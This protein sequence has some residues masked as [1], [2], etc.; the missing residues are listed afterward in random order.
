MSAVVVIPCYRSVLDPDEQLSIRQCLEVLGHHDLCVVAPEGLDL[1]GLL[2]DL[3]CERFPAGC[4]ADIGA[5]NRLL[6]GPEFYVRFARHEYLLIHQLDAYVFRDELD[7]WCGRGVDYVGAPWPDDEFLRKRKWR[8]AFPLHLRPPM[9]ARCIRCCDFRVGNG[10]FSLR[11]IP[12]FLAVLDRHAVAARDWPTNED[13][14]WSLAAPVYDRKFRIPPEREAMRF[15]VERDPARYL[16]RMAGR[17]P[18]GCH[19]WR[20]HGFVIWK[21]HLR[22]EG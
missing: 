15:A 9:L 8:S 5:Y 16:R 17:L 1:P 7:E 6:L 21:P 19:A 22:A 12:A 18:F 10:G 3:P 2:A 20:K 13:V 11:R 14:F 4:F